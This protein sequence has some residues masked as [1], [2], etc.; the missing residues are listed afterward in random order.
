MEQ[1]VEP[2]P[3]LYCR[4]ADFMCDEASYSVLHIFNHKEEAWSVFKDQQKLEIL[5]VLSIPHR[6]EELGVTQDY[7]H[8]LWLMG[9]GQLTNTHDADVVCIPSS[10]KILSFHQSGSVKSQLCKFSIK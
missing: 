9:V 5:R 4:Q 8:I 6:D 10:G 7:T 1:Q 3:Q 2:S